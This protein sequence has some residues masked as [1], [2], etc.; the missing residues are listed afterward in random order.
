MEE[1]AK[2]SRYVHEN[3]ENFYDHFCVNI[4]QHEPD[5][6]VKLLRLLNG[7]NECPHIPC[8]QQYPLASIDI[9]QLRDLI[10]SKFE[11]KLSEGKDFSFTEDEDNDED[12]QS[13]G[14]FHL[15][16]LTAFLGYPR[17]L[18]ILFDIQ[19][20]DDELTSPAP[21]LYEEFKCFICFDVMNEP[22]T[23]PCGHSACLSCLKKA[24]AIS[25]K[26][27]VCKR[28][29]HH[30]V[31]ETLA[32]SIHLRSAI[33]HI[34]R[35]LQYKRDALKAQYSILIPHDEL[36]RRALGD[37][38][39]NRGQK[40]KALDEQSAA[41]NANIAMDGEQDV[42]DEN[43]LSAISYDACKDLLRRAGC[44]AEWSGYESGVYDEVREI[45]RAFLKHMV[46]GVLA[47]T[48]HRRARTVSVDAVIAFKPLNYTVLGFGGDFGI[49]HVWSSMVIAVMSQVHP[50]IR[51][52]PQALSVLND[53]STFVM[54]AFLERA[55]RLANDSPSDLASA[56][57]I[58]EA[59]DLSFPFELKFYDYIAEGD[60]HS[61]YTERLGT[62]V[63][64]VSSKDLEN[65]M[66]FVACGQLKL[67]AASEGTKAIEKFSAPAS[68]TATAS[69]ATKAGLQCDP[70]IVALLASRAPNG[71]RMS[72]GAAVYL[73]G[74]IEYFIA[75][76]CELCGNAAKDA[77]YKAVSC[78]HVMWAIRGDAELDSMFKS[79]IIRD[80]GV[81]PHI[82]KLIVL[83]TMDGD[84]NDFKSSAFETLLK[85]K[86]N[87]S[88][89]IDPR[90]G[91]H[92]FF[93]D[94]DD[95]SA[96]E[97]GSTLRRAPVLDAMCQESLAERVALARQALSPEELALMK[98]E[99]MFL[100]SDQND[101]GWAEPSL[102]E[103]HRRNQADICRMQKSHHK[104]FNAHCF[105]RLVESIAREINA[106]GRFFTAE[107]MECMQT[108]TEGYLV[109]FLD[110][111]VANAVHADRKYL[112]A[113]DLHL[114]KR[115]RG[116]II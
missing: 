73:A 51:V 68:G 87:G 31:I 111:S 64:Y 16:R 33:G 4:L 83:P 80:G 1:K 103:L 113:K 28:Q 29:C 102:T 49:R 96:D 27:S 39:F 50:I 81:I 116:E 45:A 69:M 48:E 21:E 106:M 32:V 22:S 99:G 76:I 85:V 95:D 54:I 71:Y 41:F 57:C 10:N 104:I 26:C 9:P 86:A 25:D 98:S 17:P 77:G 114:T 7:L 15:N 12:L 34:F 44:L 65:A 56:C 40:V 55:V 110:C 6:S 35:R 67:H 2:Y 18:D 24:F 89:F 90:T 78:R 58:M 46:E 11:L 36:M 8:K 52:D 115:M 72:K 70:R 79:C 61:E 97:Y 100:C 19:P 82:H 3:T 43:L 94:S 74:A 66:Q 112:E 101:V 84:G 62:P 5:L 37:I 63:S 109:D 14:F 53:L 20:P 42:K 30:T 23:L 59:S 105:G 75:E 38:S 107:A 60:E 92:S 91:R 93:E 108:L 88:A 13:S 47:V